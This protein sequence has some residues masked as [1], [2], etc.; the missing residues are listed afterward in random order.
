[1]FHLLFIKFDGFCNYD[2]LFIIFIIHFIA[3]SKR[4]VDILRD[5]NRDVVIERMVM[6]FE[7]HCDIALRTNDSG[8]LRSI[9]EKAEALPTL[10]LL[11]SC[12]AWS[13]NTSMA[14][15]ICI[16]LPKKDCLT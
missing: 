6:R 12:T 15:K 5:V 8:L 13:A 7:I 10:L 16:Y 9:Y 2:G 4:I 14:M 1:M 3:L 11:M